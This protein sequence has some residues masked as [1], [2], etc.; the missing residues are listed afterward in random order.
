[1]CAEVINELLTYPITSK[2]VEQVA[3]GYRS[4]ALWKSIVVCDRSLIVCKNITGVGYC[5]E[6]GIAWVSKV[7][8]SRQLVGE[9]GSKTTGQ[10]PRQ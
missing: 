1:M 2:I 10:N 7:L 5:V 3:V 4:E 6:N 8:A 9:D